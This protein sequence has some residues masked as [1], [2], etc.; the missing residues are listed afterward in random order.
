MEDITDEIR[1]I[2]D[3][4][5]HP[6]VTIYALTD[7]EFCKIAGL[8]ADVQGSTLYEFLYEVAQRKRSMGYE[9]FAIGDKYIA[10]RIREAL[11]VDR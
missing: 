7:E 6:D 10:R 11:G 1:F 4:L 2:A 9:G 5:R 3:H 8:N